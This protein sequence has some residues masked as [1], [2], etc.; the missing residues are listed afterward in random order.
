MQSNTLLF[1]DVLHIIGNEKLNTTVYRR[2]THKY[3]HLEK[4]SVS[5]NIGALTNVQIKPC[6][7]KNL[8]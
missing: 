6:Q 1:L 4:N 2:N 7:K 5:L 8:I 3:L